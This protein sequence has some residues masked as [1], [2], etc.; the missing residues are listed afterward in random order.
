LILEDDPET[1][2]SEKI[3]PIDLRKAIGQKRP[4]PTEQAHEGER[5]T[6][7]VGEI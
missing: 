5:I 1:V 7:V 2:Q 6:R 4:K 3:N